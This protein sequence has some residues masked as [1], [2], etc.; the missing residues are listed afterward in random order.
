MTEAS[1]RCLAPAVTAM[2]AWADG[3]RGRG[4]AIRAA[5]P[6]A[7]VQP[8]RARR[9]RSQRSARP[10]P[11]AALPARWR[12]GSCSSA[13]GR[14]I[15]ASAIRAGARRRAGRA[16]RRQGRTLSWL[17][18]RAAD[19]RWQLL[20]L[21]AFGDTLKPGAARGHRHAQAPGA[22]HRDDQRR[23]RRQRAKRS[24]RALG[25]D[26][27]RAEVLPGDKAAV[28]AS[29][30]A[31]RARW[32]WSATASTT[33]RRWRRPTS[34]GDGH[35]QQGGTDGDAG[36]RHHADAR[37]PGAGGAGHRDL[38]P[39]HREDP[40]EPVLGFYNVVGIPLAAFGAL[41]PVVAGAAMAMSS[42]SVLS[43]ALLLKRW[44]PE[45]K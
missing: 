3:S 20:G 26:D 30:R 33:R 2:P 7:A 18:A 1:R 29:L 28:V 15:D 11:A 9:C 10:C 23:Q 12:A 27:V 36:R 17:A 43:N 5:S 19:G 39:H 32:R 44:T 34:A 35:G 22:A 41:N 40:P 14:L 37:R 16:R 6:L 38:A 13:A 42:V 45:K 25:I 24:A 8:L 4:A 21:L 31:S